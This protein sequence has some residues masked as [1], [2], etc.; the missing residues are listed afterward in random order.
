MLQ[1][2]PDEVSNLIIHCD[3]FKVLRICNS[4]LQ[5]VH[6]IQAYELHAITLMDKLFIFIKHLYTQWYV[7]L[8]SININNS[9]N[10][11]CKNSLVWG[12]NPNIWISLWSKPVIRNLGVLLLAQWD[13]CLQRKKKGRKE[14]D[15]SIH[16][17]IN[18]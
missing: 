9:Y 7:Q 3:M 14:A 8:I 15:E 12:H 1:C 17:R 18:S 4:Y 5:F 2:K 11:L 13:V 16:H 6:L 10:V